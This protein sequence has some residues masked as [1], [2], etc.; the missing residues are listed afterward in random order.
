MTTLMLPPGTFFLVPTRSSLRVV[1]GEPGIGSRAYLG[2]V[3]R[4]AGASAR[5]KTTIS[6][7]VTVLMS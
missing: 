7:P 4:R 1:A 5:V 2:L 6:S 3:S